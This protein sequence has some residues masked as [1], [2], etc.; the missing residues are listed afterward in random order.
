MPFFIGHGLLAADTAHAA[1]AP[2]ILEPDFLA[3]LQCF[4]Q[5]LSLFA[6]ELTVRSVLALSPLFMTKSTGPELISCTR[7]AV[8]IED[9]YKYHERGRDRDQVQ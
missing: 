9:K 2:Q 1:T 4:D 7:I 5:L 3:I 8:E 6:P